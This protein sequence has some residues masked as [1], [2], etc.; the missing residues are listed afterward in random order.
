M[1]E[2]LTIRN[3]GPIK[4]V[5]IELR[6][7]NVFIGDQGTGKSTIA[8]LLC[9]LKACG[10]H[11]TSNFVLDGERLNTDNKDQINKLQIDS[12][13]K[14]FLEYLELFDLFHYQS[15]STFVYYDCPSFFIKWE[16]GKF[17][18]DYK[19]GS[20]KNTD[21]SV[22]IPASRESYII[23]KD[24]YPALMNA[25]AELPWILNS[26]GQQFNNSIKSKTDYDFS[27]LLK[28]KYKRQ[29][30]KDEIILKDGTVINFNE[31]S[32]AINSL[33]PLLVVFE[34]FVRESSN[35]QIS[36][37]NKPFL[38]IEE[39]ELNCFPETQ[40]KVVE[41]LIENLT[42]YSSAVNDYYGHL[43]LTTHSPYILTT[44]NNLM[45][46]YKV[47]EN[48]GKE[49]EEV[50][51]RN[52]WLNPD[53]V[54]AYMLL[55]GGTSK[56]IIDNENGEKLIRTE[57]IDGVSQLLNIDFDKLIDIEMQLKDA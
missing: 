18:G 17:T 21:H 36:S 25:K 55:P 3:F 47:G 11:F 56:N 27:N 26:F 49:V 2:K 30:N 5:K 28:V 20:Q 38:I 8:K 57:K 48:F 50:I 9:C 52:F 13:T 35:L 41:Y 42:N 51:P 40:K 43:V 37:S 16:N 14:H 44:L 22:F 23:L 33:L 10:H 32:S 15:E 12:F 39:P 54:S 46:A 19:S 4:D 24:N 31:A 45:Y 7:V 29:G 34:G 6:A 53:D 1:S